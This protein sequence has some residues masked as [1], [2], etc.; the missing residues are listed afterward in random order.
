MIIK[1][2]NFAAF[3]MLSL[4]LL[5]SFVSAFGQEYRPLMRYPDIHEN[6]I[7][8]V[9]GNDIW[10]VP[11]GGGVAV[12]LTIDDGAETFPRFSPDGSLI[13]FTGQYDGN[14]DVYVMNIFGG[15]IQRL[16]YHPSGDYVVGWHP[17]NNKVIFFSARNGGD[18]Y[19]SL[20][21]IAPDGT[22]LEE[23]PLHEISKGTFSPDGSKIAY[24][25]VSRESRNWKRYYGGTAQDVFLYDFEQKSVRRLTDFEGTD[26][27]PMWIGDEIYFS[28]D[29]DGV[30]NIYSYD[31]KTENIEQITK[32]REYD[33]R[34][35][36]M[37]GSKIIYELGGSLW[38]LDITTKQTSRVSVE[39]KTDAPEVRPY[40]K[41]VAE[42]ITGYDCSPDGNRALITARGDLFSVP[43]E[44]GA[45]YNLTQDCGTREKDAVWSPDGKRVA[46]LSD[47]SGEYEIYI[48]DPQGKT[49]AVKLTSHDKGYRHKL[50]WSPDSKKIAYTDHSL[51]LYYLDVATKK[52]TEIDK[53]EY[54]HVDVSLHL[55]PLSDYSWS[56]DSRYIAYAKMNENLLYQNYIFSL[57]TGKINHVSNN[58]FNDFNPVFTPDGKHLLFISN[59]RFSP[60][61]CDFEWEMVYKKVAGIYALTL[62]QNGQPL[63][64]LKDES[65]EKPEESKDRSKENPLLKI[66][67]DDLADRIESIPLPRSNYRDLRVNESSI[68]YL[69][70]DE[71]DF[72]RFEFREIGPRDLFAYSIDDRK[73]KKVQSSIDSYK[74]SAN[75]KHIIYQKN[76]DEIG[77]VASSAT[78]SKGEG[79]DLSDLEIWLDPLAEWEQIYF[80]TWRLERDFFYDSNMHGLDWSAM[81]EKYARLLP[82]ASCRQDIE[83]LMGELIAELSTS[84]TYVYQGDHKRTA[85]RVNVGLLGADYEIDTENN[86]YRFKRIYRIPEWTH[87]TIPP[88]NRPGL[89]V[90][91]GDYLLAVND[92]KI[93]ADKNIYSYFQNLARKQV[94]LLVNSKP[95]FTGAK[96]I[97]VKTIS[98]EMR[99]RYIANV[100]HNRKIVN[101]ASGGLIGYI[102]LPDT[103]T[104]SAR[105]FP[106]Y[107]YSQTQK[108]GLVVDG[109]SNGGGLDPDIFLN[110]LNK[111]ILSY[112]TRRYTHDQTTPSIVTDAHMVCLTDRQAGSGGD[113]LPLDFRSMGMGPVIGTR[114]WG[115]LVGISAYMP[116]IDGGHVTVPDYRIYDKNGNWIVENYGTPVDIEIDLDPTEMENGYDAQLMKGVEVLMEMIKEDPRERPVHEPYPDRS[117]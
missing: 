9:Y 37:G 69:N 35:P 81:G 18:D 49:E 104:S 38:V 113:Q 30:L 20:F 114:T 13:A 16:T 6:S 92:Q 57:K 117:Y 111:K 82:Y 63:L 33:V 93:T 55:K 102:H 108:K 70:R 48:T 4:L 97:L 3:L 105:M 112:W 39:I 61:F 87:N 34:R 41:D 27:L 51:R 21:M 17:V 22:G 86:L 74:L 85:D 68:F 26:R 72:N 2:V 94:R 31:L 110:R 83:Y 44:D 101:E 59:R 84:H 73:E 91:N 42:F 36:S 77:I 25:K 19:S 28:S 107:F 98:S 89:N 78:E 62:Q 90:N 7:A 12:R 14:T 56:P 53:A 80:E 66:D 24:N 54:E 29:R 45:T 67:F 96:E 64:P 50:N 32:H 115:G 43:K 88:L 23:I 46:Y 8:F 99:L 58:M 76:D 65:I 106:Q 52:I 75:G 10:K 5:L 100:E 116:L 60:T 109:R 79:L 95:S 47:K 40:L 103:Y 71:G 1:K 11:A 15:D